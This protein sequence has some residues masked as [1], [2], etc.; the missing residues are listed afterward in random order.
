MAQGTLRQPQDVVWS[1]TGAKLDPTDPRALTYRQLSAQGAIDT[2]QPSGTLRNPPVLRNAG[3]EVSLDP[4]SAYIGTQGQVQFAPVQASD[5]QPQEFGVAPADPSV[6]PARPLL[7]SFQYAI[8]PS[9]KSRV[10]A[11]TRMYPSREFARDAGGRL[12]VRVSP[13]AP[14]YYLNKPGLSEQ[15]VADLGTQA[16][17]FAPAGAAAKGAN[18]LMQAGARVGAASAG[19]SAIQD[20]AT[21]QAVDPTKAALAGGGGFAGEAVGVGL[22][23]L[24]R[25][26]GRAVVN[27]TPAPVR[28]ALAGAADGVGSAFGMEARSAA[29]NPGSGGRF[30]MSR[31]QQ[32]GDFGQIAFE[33][34]AARGARGAEAT[35]VMRGFMNE[36]AQAVR[37][38]GRGLAGAD[39]LQSVPEAA[40]MVQQGMKSQAGAAKRAADEAYASL[41]S[42]DAVIAA[43]NMAELPNKIRAR[44]ADDFISPEVMSSLNPQTTG[45]FN[46]INRLAANAGK[47]MGGGKVVGFPV[48]GVE[49]VRQAMNR[50]L[51]TAQGQD[52][53]ALSIMKNEFDG[54]L[55]DAIDSSLISGDRSAIDTLKRAR[56]LHSEYRRNFGGTR[57]DD[58]A[59]RLMRSLIGANANESDAVNL[60]FGRAELSGSG[61]AVQLVKAIKRVSQGGPEVQALREGAVMRL[62]ARLDRNMGAGATNVNYKALADDWER[63]LS[64]PSAP[65]MRELFD[66]A[67]LREMRGFIRDVRRLAPPEG[68]VNRSGSGYE[69]SRAFSGLIGKLKIIAPIAKGMDDAAN[70]VRARSAV[71]PGS[72]FQHVPLSGPSGAAIGS[73]QG[74]Q[75]ANVAN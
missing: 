70:A 6:R 28:N 30:P 44:L 40:G 11:I 60:L 32:T 71:D 51:T 62:M 15:D 7:N 14:W 57:K 29:R 4:G 12:V 52:R 54:W 18:T 21:Q 35:D 74:G 53:A 10:D 3:D 69:V 9:E 39:S 46:E 20:I 41:R 16:L 48:A 61:D 63:A 56:G 33:Q 59:Q 72:P 36:Q 2:T 67:E 42:S 24:A 68:S 22:N 34:A 49:R 38:T 73:I 75:A 37:Q 25:G 64:G 45:I 19:I 5:I 23:A 66:A 55:N 31:G 1:D 65:I 47:P 50:S 27:A 17:M 43:P 58:G 13:T 8:N 26:T